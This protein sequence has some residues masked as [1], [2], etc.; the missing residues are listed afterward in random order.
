MSQAR[1]SGLDRSPEASHQVDQQVH[2]LGRPWE[3]KHR[4]QEKDTPQSAGQEATGQETGGTL[5]RW[6]AQDMKD[7]PYHDIGAVAKK[8]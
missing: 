8:G 4:G 2:Q 3:G 1:S 6:A 7:E 5:D